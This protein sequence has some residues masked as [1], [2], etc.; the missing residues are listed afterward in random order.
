MISKY[1]VLSNMLPIT[2]KHH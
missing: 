1:R 2:P